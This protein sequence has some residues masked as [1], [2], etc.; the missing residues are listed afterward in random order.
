MKLFE[1]SIGDIINFYYGS[2]NY[3]NGNYKIYSIGSDRI[4]AENLT[5]LNNKIAVMF[6]END[7]QYIKLINHLKG[8]I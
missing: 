1:L 5:N 8:F 4:W 2:D 3:F 7:L 6:D